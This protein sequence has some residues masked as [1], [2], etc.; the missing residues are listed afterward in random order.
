MYFRLKATHPTFGEL[1]AAVNDEGVVLFLLHDVMEMFGLKPACV[2]M[3]VINS[4]G[5]LHWFD[6]KLKE[7][8]KVVVPMCDELIF[9]DLTCDV[10]EKYHRAVLWVKKKLVP[11][12]KNPMRR[13][14][15]D[16]DKK[17]VA[18][19]EDKNLD[20]HF[21]DNVVMINDQ[22]YPTKSIHQ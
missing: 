9:D 4:K 16:L 3:R 8:G 15:Y 7:G 17:P 20:V 13:T 2:C 22:A 14:R 18:E 5:T 1:R 10:G 21:Y 12:F 6:C 19:R 11:D